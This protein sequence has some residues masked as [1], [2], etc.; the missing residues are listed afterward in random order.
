M[1]MKL[2]QVINKYNELYNVSNVR[3]NKVLYNI[4]KNKKILMDEIETYNKQ[5]EEI[6]D[7][8]VEKDENGNNKTVIKVDEFNGNKERILKFKVKEDEKTTYEKEYLEELTELREVE[9]DLPI[10][11]IKFDDLEKDEGKLTPTEMDAI[12]FMIEE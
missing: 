8:Y 3:N 9:V 10:R 6:S 12:F 5:A 2:Y 4:S 11:M 7:K 1:K